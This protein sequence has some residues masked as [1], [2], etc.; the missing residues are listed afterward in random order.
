[1]WWKNE[2][3]VKNKSVKKVVG[4]DALLVVVIL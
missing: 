3:V 4:S 2:G 1:M